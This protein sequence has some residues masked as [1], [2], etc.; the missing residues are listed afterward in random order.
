MKTKIIKTL[1]AG[2]LFMA[3]AAGFAAP[4]LPDFVVTPGSVPGVT[5][6]APFTADKITGNYNEAFTVTGANTFITKAY[7]DA[8]QF[9][10]NDGATPLTAKLTQLGN[11]Y[12]LYAVFDSVGTFAT[13]AD[14]SVFTGGTGSI[15]IYIDAALDTTK[16]LGATGADDIVIGDNA[17]DY[18]IATSDYLI[19][20]AGTQSAGLANGDFKFVFGDFTLTPE[21]ASFF[22]SPSPFYFGLDLAGQFNSFEISGNQQINGSADAWF[23]VPEPAGLA[24]IGFALSGLGL[25]GRRRKS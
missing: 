12:G 1:S 10:K 18:L 9:V 19:A 6:T 8:G 13:S 5:D 24:L 14:G 21:G 25:F 23:G 4:V 20:A 16:A 22:T 2:A 7:W 17:D 3:S 15:K 11:S